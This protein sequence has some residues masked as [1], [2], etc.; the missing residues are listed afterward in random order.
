MR[1]NRL[2]KEL[3]K[4]HVGPFFFCFFT[5]MFILLMQ[6]LILYVDQLVGKGLD[7]TIVIELILSNLAYM[8][9]LAVPMAVLVST[10]IAFGQFAEWNELTALKAAG[11]NPFSLMKPLLAVSILLFI[12][13]SYFSNNILPEANH[14]AR[15]LFIDIRMQKPAFDLEPGIFYNDIEGYTF[16]VQHIPANSDTLYDITLFQEGTRGRDQ[17]F[18]KAEKGWLESPDDITLSLFLLNG[19]TINQSTSG[20]SNQR[21]VERSRFRKYRV[22][23][24]LSD[25][26]FSPTNPEQRGRNDRTMS[27]RAMMAVLDTLKAE[28]ENQLQ[29]FTDRSQNRIMPER[30]LS[31]L[32]PIQVRFGPVDSLWSYDSRFFILNQMS[33][34]EEQTQ[35]LT[36]ATSTI[37]DI[38]NETET[39][40]ESVRWRDTRI[41]EYLVE[42][43]KKF[44][45][46]FACILFVLIGAP[47]GMMTRKGNIGFAAIISAVLLT[48]YFMAI[49]QGEKW[50]DR[51]LLTPFTGMWGINILMGVTGILLTLHVST[52]L[53][54]SPTRRNS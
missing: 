54:L 39:L 21:T 37:S 7:M 29:E 44:S 41:A 48:L 50:A 47:I 8:V 9:V 28:Q 14:K 43:H 2:Q 5:I 42:I 46:P 53:R 20:S 51:L 49:I 1:L 18:I 33:S 12:G 38:R 26:V 36:Q 22:S 34:A 13:L 24:D 4:R 6:F 15:S 31:E 11:V 25:M 16:L 40:H 35:V 19:T 27:S 30:D 17:T 3:L 23:F 52:S 45:I 32:Q 10:L